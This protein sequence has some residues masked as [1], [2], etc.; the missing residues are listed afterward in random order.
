[1][2]D[3]KLINPVE[4][5]KAI[6]A[7]IKKHVQ[8]NMN[9][10]F[11]KETMTAKNDQPSETIPD[12]TM[13]M[14]ELVERYVKGQPIDGG[15]KQPLYYGDDGE[16][17]NPATMDLVERAEHVLK[18]TEELKALSEKY[19]GKQPP[20]IEAIEKKESMEKLNEEFDKYEDFVKFRDERLKGD[21]GKKSEDPHE[22]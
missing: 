14:A 19:S 17:I 21:P 13:S 20:P 3:D 22:K 12:Q 9:F 16:G 5:S 10:K 4:E 7:K 18:V 11:D 1:M 6:K 8:N 2:K 15:V